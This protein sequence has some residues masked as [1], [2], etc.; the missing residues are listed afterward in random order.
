MGS[1]TVSF[2]Y[3]SLFHKLLPKPP[4]MDRQGQRGMVGSLGDIVGEL[5]RSE[6]SCLHPRM[7]L[8]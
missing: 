4:W 3:R 6:R 7:V 8:R 2:L 5:D 1:L